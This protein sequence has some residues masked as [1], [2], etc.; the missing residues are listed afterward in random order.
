LPLNQ[1][2]AA[3]PNEPPIKNAIISIVEALGP[4]RNTRRFM[5][6]S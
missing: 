5:G 2:A 3:L 4:M 6:L 1:I